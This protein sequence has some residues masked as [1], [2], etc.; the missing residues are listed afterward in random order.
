[1]QYL[2]DY[3]SSDK[4]HVEESHCCGAEISQG[5]MVR[6]KRTESEAQGSGLEKQ[7]PRDWGRD[8]LALP[9]APLL[10]CQ[11]VGPQWLPEP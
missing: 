4:D 3:N 11:Q 6:S 1:M 9:E 2:E 8:E 7:Q 5:L 10:C